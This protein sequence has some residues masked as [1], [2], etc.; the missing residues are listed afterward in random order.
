MNR[1]II[2]ELTDGKRKEGSL[3]AE[4]SPNT[5]E[6][7]VILS[8]AGEQRKLSLAEVCAVLLEDKPDEI[9][10]AHNADVL[11]EVETTT[12]KSFQVRV[13]EDQ[14]FQ[15]GFY[16]FSIEEQASHRFIFFPYSGV[17]M[18]RQYRPVGEILAEE[19]L[20]SEEAIEAAIEE[21]KK[22]KELRIGEI[23]AEHC[24]LPQEHIEQS[25]KEAQLAGSIP[26][27]ARIGDILVASGLVTKEQVEAALAS[28]KMGQKK[29]IG[30]ILMERGLLTEEQLLAALATK[31]RLRFVDLRDIEPDE[32][33][34]AAIS[35]EMVE[36]LQ[37]LPLEDH[38]DHLTVA[39]SQPTDPSI[40][41]TLRF[42]AQRRIEL[43]VATSA[44]ISAAIEKYY[45]GEEVV[46]AEEESEVE[47]IL[48]ELAEEELEAGEVDEQE[49]ETA[50][51]ESDSQ[52]ITLV[53]KILLDAYRK[54]ASD[55]HIEP[56]M[57][58]QPVLVR[59]RVD[60]ICKVAHRVPRSFKR[61]II[62]RIKILSNLDIS[63]RRKPQ[64]GKILISYKRQKIEFRVETT[65]TVGSNE[66]AVLRI[67]AASKPLAL[68]EMGFSDHNLVNFEKILAKPYGIILC[69]GPTGSGKTTT[70]HSALGHINKPDRKIW[71]A[72]DPVEITQPGLRQ[73]QVLPKIGFTFSAALRSFLRADPDVIM[74]GEMRDAE[75][76]K[77]AIEASLTGHLVFS[78]LHT[79]SAPETVVRLIEM[80]MDP[81]SFSD[82]ML[83]V[84]A[85][86]LARRLCKDCK[87][88]YHPDQ[89]EFE[90]LVQSYMPEWYEEHK[91]PEYT[92]D[93]ELMRAVGCDKCGKSGYKGRVAVHELLVGTPELKQAIKRQAPAE[94]LM[95]LAIK[96]G[97]RTL[98]MDAIAKVFD[99]IT[100]LEHVLRVCL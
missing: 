62:A 7:K 68:S 74:I 37:V 41:D 33:A 100:D 34:L 78:T 25:V 10:D 90:I 15:T 4:F 97:M 19:G 79:N 88:S 92:D 50:V 8:D 95:M 72:E 83:G 56:G 77:I 49:D 21:Q 20:V 6:I 38:P 71:T 58:S 54:G 51:K 87:E 89:D 46:L 93:L 57:G 31:F 13:P 5:N 53:N 36:Q 85:Q 39:T 40:G 1:T 76:A 80:G 59:Y 27:R 55:I 67:L 60:G 86:R 84:L 75:T 44:Q 98:K 63:E 14:A 3:A 28:Q 42:H 47:E 26:I 32:K 91:M 45:H 12:G 23:I 82:A 94:E 64:S 17:R 73:V 43:V 35:L 30:D 96:E 81:I 16:G 65:P 69:V 66:D 29:R 9:E 22:A 99:G 61:A 11:E 18:R 48:G 2:L 24:Q 70:L 52:T